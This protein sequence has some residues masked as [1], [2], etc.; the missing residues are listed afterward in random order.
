MPDR[1][2]VLIL[3]H[4]HIWHRNIGLRWFRCWRRTSRRRHRPVSRFTGLSNLLQRL[5]RLFE[6]EPVRPEHVRRRASAITDDGGENDGTIDRRP[7]ATRSSSSSFED[8]PE[9]RRN[10]GRTS[11]TGSIV[12]APQMRRNITLE[13]FYLD[14]ADCQYKR[15]IGILG[16]RQQKMFERH[17]GMRLLP[18]VVSGARQRL[19]EIGRRRQN[20]A[21][22]VDDGMRHRRCP[23]V[24]L[25]S[26]AFRV[27]HLP[28]SRP[29]RCPNP[30]IS[31]R[32]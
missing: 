29:R 28:G 15:R 11:E 31:T 8:L 13:L 24:Q 26:L 18:R 2:L 21:D 3:G 4:H 23:L 32:G 17:L 6:G 27:H 25:L 22:L 16:Q 9:I 19:G 30:Q 7:S 1:R 5:D 20:A 14:L 10:T 12:L